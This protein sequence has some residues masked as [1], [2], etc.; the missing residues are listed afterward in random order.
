MRE[1]DDD[2][3]NNNSRNGRTTK[4]ASSREEEAMK[5]KIKESSDM[6]DCLRTMIHM[7]SDAN[8]NSDVDPTSSVCSAELAASCIAQSCCIDVD[9]SSATS[10][11]SA[12]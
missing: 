5:H 12:S 8:N 3:T 7:F 9:K 11:A 10:S 2:Q 1:N 6:I 4:G